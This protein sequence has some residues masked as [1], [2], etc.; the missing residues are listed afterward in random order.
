[1]TPEYDFQQIC[2]LMRQLNCRV[3]PQAPAHPEM[4]WMAGF[5]KVKLWDAVGGIP[6]RRHQQWECPH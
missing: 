6:D 5:T 1:M 2:F 3:D 4:A